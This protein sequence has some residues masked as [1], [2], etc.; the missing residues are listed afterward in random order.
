MQYMNRS[1]LFSIFVIFAIGFGIYTYLYQS[2]CTQPVQF[3]IRNI[4]SRFHIT[5]EH[6]LKIA[7]KSALLWNT[8]LGKNVLQYNTHAQLPINFVYDHRQENLLAHE[9]LASQIDSAQKNLDNVN[10]TYTSLL[11][12]YNAYKAKYESQVSYWNARGG[13]PQ[14][15]YNTLESHR[16]TL[17][18]YVDRLNALAV[19]S[20]QKVKQGNTIIDAY[21]AT[22]KESE[23]GLYQ[24]DTSHGIYDIEIYQFSNDNDLEIVLAH[25]MGHAIG[26]GHGTNPDSIM[27]PEHT[28]DGTMPAKLTQSDI[29][30]LRTLCKVNPAGL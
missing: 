18:H 25:E 3:S 5:S 9:K 10:A 21:N 6:A 27:S 17:N 14:D 1:S 23:A 2:P 16:Q 8:A 20:T 24:V 15:A 13:A 28:F 19:T 22:G 12:E 26:L 29:D 11:N 7:E 30:A 4:D